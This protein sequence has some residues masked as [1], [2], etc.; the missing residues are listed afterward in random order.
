MKQGI[1]A[2]LDKKMDRGEFL[3]YL[4]LMFVT[5]LGIS[6]ILNNLSQLDKNHNTNYK[7]ATKGFGSG[8][9]GV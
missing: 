1:L 2:V 7:K 5:A 3:K 8:P 9:Y 6:S 4:G